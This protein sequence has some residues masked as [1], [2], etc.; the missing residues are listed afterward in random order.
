MLII[1]SFHCVTHVHAM[2]PLQVFRS[3]ACPFAAVLHCGRVQ[4]VSQADACISGT[5]QM[6][7]D[8]T[9]LGKARSAISA[10]AEARHTSDCQ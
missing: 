1:W 10:Q 4:A 3:F 8:Y 2:C 6:E 5:H 7:M 9:G